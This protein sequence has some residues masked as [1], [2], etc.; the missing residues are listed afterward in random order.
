MPFD[1]DINE[2][3]LNLN[4]EVDI[5]TNYIYHLKRISQLTLKTNQF[6][7][8]GGGRQFRQGGMGGGAPNF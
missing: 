7:R 2:Y 5:Y 8:E 1:T 4:I 6:N 3:L